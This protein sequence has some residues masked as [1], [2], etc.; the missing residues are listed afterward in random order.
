MARK[1]KLKLMF[2]NVQF[3][4]DILRGI[5]LGDEKERKEIL[6]K[7][8]KEDF[9][10]KG[11]YDLIGLCEIWDYDYYK[12]IKKGLADIYPYAAHGTTAASAWEV[13]LPII[14]GAFIGG[15]L[16]ALAGPLGGWIGGIFGG[17]VGG[18]APAYSKT[19]YLGD[20]LM[21]LSRHDFLEQPSSFAY[22]DE[23]GFD[24]WASKGGLICTI[25]IPD[26]KGK[27]KNTEGDLINIERA[28]ICVTHL[29]ADEIAIIDDEGRLFGSSA[30][31]TR[32][33]QLNQLNQVLFAS[34][35][36]DRHA[37][38]FIMGDLNVDGKFIYDAKGNI[39]HSLE[40]RKMMRILSSY[41]DTWEEHRLDDN[42]QDQ[43]Y[44]TVGGSQRLDY[45]MY[46]TVSH[47]YIIPKLMEA[48]VRKYRGRHGSYEGNISDHYGVSAEYDIDLIEEFGDITYSIDLHN[49][50]LH[51]K[52]ALEESTLRSLLAWMELAPIGFFQV[53]PLDRTALLDIRFEERG[54]EIAM[55]KLGAIWINP[56]PIVDGDQWAW[57]IGH[58][59]ENKQLDFPYMIQHYTGLAL[60]DLSPERRKD[61]N[62]ILLGDDVVENS[63][64]CPYDKSRQMN[65][66]DHLS[67]LTGQSKRGFYKNDSDGSDINKITSDAEYIWKLYG[68]RGEDSITWMSRGDKAS[69]LDN[70]NV[71][72]AILE[73]GVSG[74]LGKKIELNDKE[75]VKLK[76]QTS[77]V[78][79]TFP[80]NLTVTLV[81]VQMLKSGAWLDTAQKWAEVVFELTVTADDEKKSIRY[82][83][84]KYTTFRKKGHT[85]K[86]NESLGIK[87][88]NHPN[89]LLITIKTTELDWDTFFYR[90][91]DD[92]SRGGSRVNKEHPW[93]GKPRADWSSQK[94]IDHLRLPTN[95]E[96][97]ICIYK[98]YRCKDKKD[99]AISD[100][101]I[102]VMFSADPEAKTSFLNQTKK[103]EQARLNYN[104][105]SKKMDAKKLQLNTFRKTGKQEFTD[106]VEESILNEMKKGMEKSK[107]KI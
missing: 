88:P 99:R 24:A 23:S 48:E 58:D 34:L 78:Q 13:V 8:I 46:S 9:K 52:Q 59:A 90:N 12:D 106:K 39:T 62:P 102:E 87:V 47:S 28:I 77:T 7:K 55:V 71:I 105:L 85:F 83:R 84:E 76:P 66:K 49:K 5:G 10:T 95:E 20:G 32:R 17:L 4:T 15:V 40:Y 97:S 6:I 37:T 70:S 98:K 81:K 57:G 104:A 16:G 18:G 2:Y 44:T 65:A 107:L 86:I 54:V 11:P 29:N 21:V 51:N 89:Q 69:A 92:L 50:D 93:A 73:K 91:P 101:Y 45:I 43:G 103:V 67:S 3:F 72:K 33:K 22:A 25:P 35:E 79:P 94:A 74:S 64:M 68:I 26:E 27:T 14:V 60:R 100:F 80:I 41:K 96:N 75:L 63:I 53:Q 1:G 38:V 30:A 19:D 56:D 31:I 36:R 42:S 61:V 82:P